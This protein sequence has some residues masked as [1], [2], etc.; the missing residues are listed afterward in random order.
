MYWNKTFRNI[1]VFL[2]LIVHVCHSQNTVLKG[3]VPTYKGDKLTFYKYADYISKSKET[4]CEAVVDTSGHFQCNFI[5]EETIK[6]FVDLGVYEGHFFAEP[7][8]VYDLKLPQKTEKQIE[9]KLNPYFEP[10]II[11]LGIGNAGKD[12]LNLAIHMFNDSYIPYYNKHV[13]NIESK[14]DFTL[15]EQAIKKMN[16][17]F[18][19]MG[20]EFFRV[21]VK[22]K[23]G[24]LKHLALQQ[25]AKSISDEYFNKSK[26][27]YENPAYMEL[28]N[29]VYNK[30][31]MFLS[32]TKN[33]SDIYND[34]S[35]NKNYWDLNKTLAKDKVLTNDTLRELVILKGLHDEFY[36][37]HFSRSAMLTVL[38][39]L[40][41]VTKIEKHKKIASNIRNKVT[42]L[43]KGF[44]PPNFS[45]YDIDSN[46][47]SLNDFKGKYVYINFCSSH[48]Y[49]CLKEFETLNVIYEK[50][51][52]W[53]D[54][55]TVLLDFEYSTFTSFVSQND[56]NWHFLYYGNTPS[57]VI[58]YDIRA[59]PTYYLL[60]KEGK[61]AISPAPSPGEM[62][63]KYLFEIMRA[64]G[65]I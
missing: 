43:L 8:A 35:K 61:L 2:F 14:K 17:P 42:K 53:L 45:L 41:A 18:L 3:H 25:K 37:D 40:H 38:D 65:D 31:F 48:S 36:A 51:K 60:D 50:H 16:E 21:Y 59:F 56:Y 1:I 54:I 58:D 27:Y 22:Y 20:N 33:G 19:E 10:V 46:L 55:V 39:S 62:F 64:N 12:D 32:R 44:E 52:E 57:I 23:T 13:R 63:E 47:Y 24:L 49:T 11:H 7:G 9:D 4:V 6:L 29:Q 26:V 34:I 5:T 30:Y 28:F 15:L